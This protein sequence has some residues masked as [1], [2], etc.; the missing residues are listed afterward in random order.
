MILTN[1]ILGWRILLHKHI[2]VNAALWT[3]PEAAES[4]YMCSD[5]DTLRLKYNEDEKLS[6]D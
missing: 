1:K 4:M 2:S 3:P 5:D 6:L